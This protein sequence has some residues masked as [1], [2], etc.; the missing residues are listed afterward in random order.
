MVASEECDNGGAS[1]R[2]FTQVMFCCHR[3]QSESFERA[4]PLR[5]PHTRRFASFFVE[6]QPPPPPWTT[7]AH[8]VQ[9]CTYKKSAACAMGQCWFAPLAGG[10]VSEWA[11]LAADW[12]NEFGRRGDSHE[13]DA[14]FSFQRQGHPA[15]GFFP[16]SAKKLHFSDARVKMNK[17]GKFRIHAISGE[18]SLATQTKTDVGPKA[19]FWWASVWKL[20]KSISSQSQGLSRYSSKSVARFITLFGWPQ[21]NVTDQRHSLA[22]VSLEMRQ[23]S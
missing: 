14:C 19:E 23:S 21:A 12:W 11:L 10:R 2:A 17:S 9:R 18:Q 20:L 5:N 6:S 1:A 8:K 16:R 7:C 15:P 4:N 3:P 13:L 22:C